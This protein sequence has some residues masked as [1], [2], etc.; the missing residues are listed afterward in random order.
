MT[1][2][3]QQYQSFTVMAANDTVRNNYKSFNA[4]LEKWKQVRDKAYTVVARNIEPDY[5]RTQKGIGFNGP[6]V[7]TNIPSMESII[8]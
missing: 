5:Y 2:T 6:T 1:C 3:E 8:Q 4:C 7:P